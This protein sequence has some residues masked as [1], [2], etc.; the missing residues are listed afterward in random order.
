VRVLSWDDFI[1][2]RRLKSSELAMTIGVFD[3]VHYGHQRLI[4]QVISQPVEIHGVLTFRYNPRRFLKPHLFPGDITSGRQ[5]LNILS[6]LG[7]D[8]I[9]LIDFSNDF[10][11]LSGNE[12]IT[13]I[14]QSCDLRYL[15]LGDNFRCGYQGRSSAYDL[16][17]ILAASKI[18][19]EIVPPVSYNGGTLSSTRIRA[20][21]REGE[22][23]R[24]SEM[25]GRKFVLDIAG[26]PQRHEDS[27][28]SIEKTGLSQVLPPVGRYKVNVHTSNRS[29]FSDVLI[30]QECLRWKQSGEDEAVYIEFL[31][32]DLSDGKANK[33][34]E[35][36]I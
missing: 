35:T 5:K 10:S 30:D 21:I 3:G 18:P 19:V 4:Q 13:K 25:M 31:S 9:I 28:A 33:I 16:R 36:N 17:D 24:T 7:I 29:F 27:R 32:N 14:R 11:K 22:L 2:S 26:I 6:S 34:D 1:G 8:T 23:E 12:F 20:A 15:A